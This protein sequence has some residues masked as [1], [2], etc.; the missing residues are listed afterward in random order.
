ME[1][2]K[3]NNTT[4]ELEVVEMLGIDTGVRVDL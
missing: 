1:D 4:D 2:G 3:T